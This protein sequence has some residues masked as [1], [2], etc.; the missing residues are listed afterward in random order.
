[1]KLLVTGGSGF[2]G[3][4]VCRR[5]I[6]DGNDVVSVSRSGRPPG[7]DGWAGE[8]EWIAADVFDP[9]AWREHLREC[10]AVVHS[11]GIIGEAP[12]EGVTFER[13]NGDSAILS[14]LEAERAGV[15]RFVFVSS[16]NTPPLVRDA[17]IEAKR[18]AERSIA[19]LDLGTVV[20]RPG[21]VYGPDQP[22]FPR[23]VNAALRTMDRV[24]G[25]GRLLGEDRPLPVGRVAEAVY[26]AAI[27]D[28][29]AAFLDAPAIAAMTGK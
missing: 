28:A 12:A 3:R 13:V 5:A 21:P 26:A 14:A 22:H 7:L 1:M 25:L 23:A 29:D 2:I 15:E 6:A 16:S 27:G 20:L 9:S 11:I 24:P 18:R 8:V 19:G 17:Y 10:S 4:A